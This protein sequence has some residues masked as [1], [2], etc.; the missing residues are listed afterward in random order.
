MSA[1]IEP[2]PDL[3]EAYA[4]AHAAYSRLYPALKEATP[5]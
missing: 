2:I 5:R 3:V 1:M 4:A